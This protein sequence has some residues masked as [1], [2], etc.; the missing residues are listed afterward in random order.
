MKTWNEIKV[1]F[2][3]KMWEL[4]VKAEA[5][6]QQVNQ[7]IQDNKEIVIAMIPVGIVALRGFTNTVKSIDRKIDMKKEQELKDKYVYD[8]STGMYL[9]LRRPMKYS[10]HIEFDRRRQEG[11]SKIQILASMGLLD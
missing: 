4:R 3:T 8:H 2:D 7:W 1:G 9:K 5:K 11:E 6:K 10:E